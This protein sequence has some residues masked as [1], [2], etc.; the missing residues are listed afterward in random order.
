MITSY[1]HDVDE[2]RTRP[3]FA[4]SRKT[5]CLD[6]R[7]PGEPCA[8]LP[9]DRLMEPS[10]RVPAYSRAR[11]SVCQLH[12]NQSISVEKTG[13]TDGINGKM[14]K[15]VPSFSARQQA[16]TRAHRL[17]CWVRVQASARR[18]I[19]GPEDGEHFETLG[20]LVHPTA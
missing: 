9:L 18:M 19:A 15:K 8:R 2:S 11:S 14:G 3:L 17:P 16:T 1:A 12:P 13:Q 10:A 5:N 7:S 6:A 20:K 4:Q